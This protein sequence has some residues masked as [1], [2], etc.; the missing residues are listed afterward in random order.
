MIGFLKQLN[1][2]ALNAQG[3]QRSSPDEP[4]GEEAALAEYAAAG[5]KLHAARN[6]YFPKDEDANPEQV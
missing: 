4:Q 1:V 6:H 3:R 2:L 5:I